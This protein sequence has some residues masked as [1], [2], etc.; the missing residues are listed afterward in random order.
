MHLHDK[1]TIDRLIGKPLCYL[2][3]PIVRL[4]GLIL[5][6]DHSINNDN[7][8]C[9]AVAKYI[10]MGSIVHSL[11]MLKALRVRYPS[12]QIIYITVISNRDLF[13][14][15]DFFNDVFYIDDSSLWNIVTS[16][17]RLFIRLASLKVDLYFDLE[18]FSSYGALVSLISLARNR[19]GFL[20]TEDTGF[21]KYLYTHLMY[22][23]MQMPIRLCYMQLARIADVSSRASIELIP[24]KLDKSLLASTKSKVENIIGFKNEI[25][26]VAINI[27]ASDFS[28]ERRWPKDR[29]SVVAR[30]LS[31]LDYTVFF[32]GSKEEQQY[33]QGAVDL[34]PDIKNQ[35]FNLAGCL[36]LSESLALLTFC[37][38][39]ITND[40][41]PMAFAYSLRVPT[42][43][44][45]GPCH[46]VQYHVCSNHSVFL[47]KPIYCSPCTHLLYTPPC[48]GKQ[49][50]MS[51]ISIEE[52]L[53]ALN[54]II[55]GKNM[56]YSSQFTYHHESMEDVLLGLLE[57]R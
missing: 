29:F 1:V 47:Y 20:S 42:V 54:T 55:I 45:F 34:L 23:N 41:G 46:P 22:L 10:G 6:R 15:L 21:K 43:S 57:S 3:M 28:K 5:R 38:L 8:Q 17:F 16:T 18:I 19:I 50:C 33:V 48:K 52:V 4:V 11:P 30:Y 44:L 56:N 13:S 26:F 14:H 36:T 25:K 37:D 9:I 31:E 2:L 53:V 51:S 27:N 40:T 49:Y 7:V 12:S 24:L 35:V 32:I 39:L